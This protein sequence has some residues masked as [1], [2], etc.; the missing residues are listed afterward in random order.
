VPE[1]Q[2]ATQ[3]APP[4]TTG[5]PDAPGGPR[6]RTLMVVRVV[7]TAVR[8]LPMHGTY[9]VVPLTAAPPKAAQTCAFAS[10]PPMPPRRDA[11][12][13]KPVPP[14]PTCTI[15]PSA[16]S[17]GDMAPRSRSP[18][19]SAPQLRGEKKPIRLSRGVS[20]TTESLPSYGGLVAAPLPTAT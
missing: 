11:L 10:W 5:E 9:T 16:S 12:S 4:P 13:R 17:A 19:L 14:L 7:R 8:P 15:R 6:Q 20:A 18:A 3:T 1:F 2:S